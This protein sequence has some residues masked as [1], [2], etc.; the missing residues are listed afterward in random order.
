MVRLQVLY[1]VRRQHS[2]V[3]VFVASQWQSEPFNG[4]GEKTDWSVAL[5]PLKRLQQRGE[6]TGC[7]QQYQAQYAVPLAMPAIYAWFAVPLR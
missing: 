3:I 5:Y 7:F 6:E 2:G 4:I 1:L